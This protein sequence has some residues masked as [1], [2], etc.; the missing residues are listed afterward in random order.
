MSIVQEFKQFAMKGNVVD[1]AIGVI[2][3]SAFGKIVSSL[4]ENILMPPIGL[5]IGGVDFSELKIIIQPAAGS[6]Q[7][8]AV[9]Y[10][11]FLQTIINFLIVAWALFL[12]IKAINKLER[13]KPATAL[14]IPEDILLLR[15]IRDSLKK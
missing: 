13:K 3:G 5:L 14:A 15:E 9:G 8:V 7:E 6:A 2:I 11:V 12:V 10:G 1:L 4:V